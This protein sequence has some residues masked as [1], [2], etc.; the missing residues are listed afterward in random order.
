[1]TK[2]QKR[3]SAKQA[4]VLLDNPQF[5]AAVE[6]C[7]HAFGWSDR[8]DAA[9]A[10][11]SAEDRHKLKHKRFF[12]KWGV[13]VPEDG[14]LVHTDSRRSEAW[15]LLAGRLGLVRVFPWT[16]ETQVV[17]S[18]K[19]IRRLIGRSERVAKNER[20]AAIAAWLAKCGF[21]NTEIGAAVWGLR[22]GLK[23]PRK[24]DIN[25][26]E[27]HLRRVD[28]LVATL[29]EAAAYRL[30]RVRKRHPPP[31]SVWLVLVTVDGTVN[32]KRRSR[33]CW[34]RTP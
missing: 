7:R 21:S 15:A 18:F 27:S 12:E 22:K 31:R 32:G 23:R 6:V 33:R 16:T 13:V 2:H 14:A 25:R 1:M 8:G 3:I 5:A 10:R 17:T 19:Q 34:S 30:S 28:A 26:T 9:E 4:I 20:K 29:G 24:F 11:Q